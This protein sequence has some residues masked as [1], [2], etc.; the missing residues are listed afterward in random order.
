MAKY[1]I[2]V[3]KEACIAC[4]ICYSLDPDHFKSDDSG[5]SEVKGGKTED[6]ESVGKFDDDKKEKAKEAARAC[7]VDAIT[8]KE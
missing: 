5:K 7:P 1:K 4:G 3:D 8:I 6:K 2:V